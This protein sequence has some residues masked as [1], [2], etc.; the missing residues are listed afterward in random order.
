MSARRPMY[1]CQRCRTYSAARHRG[2]ERVLKNF[3]LMGRPVR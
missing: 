3:R 2:C 1:W